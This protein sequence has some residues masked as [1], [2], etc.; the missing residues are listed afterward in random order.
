[1]KDQIDAIFSN[2]RK[3]QLIINGKVIEP[4]LITGSNVVND[5]QSLSILKEVENQREIHERGTHESKLHDFIL[6]L[7]IIEIFKK[8]HNLNSSEAMDRIRTQEEKKAL[9]NCYND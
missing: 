7:V 9:F 6:P 2:S 8:T 5:N 1:M 4:W 3:Q